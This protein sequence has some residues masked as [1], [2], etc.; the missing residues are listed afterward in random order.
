M[1]LRLDEHM[2]R[3]NPRLLPLSTRGR[4]ALPD[5]YRQELADG[6]SCV[7]VAERRS[8]EV[9]VGMAFGRAAVRE[10]LVA[11]HIGR[12]D[13]VWVEP[14]FRRQGICRGLLKQLLVFFEQK[15]VQI[16]DLYYTVSNAEAEYAWH[17]LGF[18]PVLTV[19]SAKVRDI[20]RQLEHK[21]V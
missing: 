7:L 17:D 8:T 11:S 5:R 4:D 21:A 13:D 12:I 6:S 9:L 20:I 19:A 1:R 2:A 14:S 10:D 18:R 15:G 16:L 3:T